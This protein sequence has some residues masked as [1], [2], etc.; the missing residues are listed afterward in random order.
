MIHIKNFQDELHIPATLK[1]D[2]FN[3]VSAPRPQTEYAK[4]LVV[5]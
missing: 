1:V 5:G 4:A 2:L 3:L